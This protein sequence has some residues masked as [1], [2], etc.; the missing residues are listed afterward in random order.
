MN[1]HFAL[2]SGHAAGGTAAVTRKPQ[3]PHFQKVNPQPGHISPT[4]LFLDVNPQWAHAHFFFSVSI[5]TSSSRSRDVKGSMKRQ[6]YEPFA[7][8]TAS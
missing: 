1:S 6:L 5:C 2:H 3:Q 7:R 8:R 4:N